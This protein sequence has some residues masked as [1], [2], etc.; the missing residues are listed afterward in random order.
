VRPEGGRDSSFL[1][2]FYNL[3]SDMLASIWLSLVLSFGLLAFE[4]H[5][6]AFPLASDSSSISPPVIVIGFVG[7]FVGHDNLVHS[8]VQL[9]ARLHHD[10]PSGVY[11]EAFENRRREI[12]HEKI[13]RL[14]DANH[15]GKLSAE[16][17]Q[18]AR[19]V[20]YGMSWGAS[21]SVTLARELEKDGI[22]VL[23]T[24]QVDSVSKVSQNDALIPG[25]VAEAANFYQTDGLL[26]G[27]SEIR[28]ADA[29]HTRIIG[30]FRFDYRANPI[31][32]PQYP[33]YDRW[34][35]KSHTEIE[36]DPAVWKHVESLIRSKLPAPGAR[37]AAEGSS[38]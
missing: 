38:Q 9:A 4:Q 1:N 33:W 16:E 14:L 29:T 11:V 26:H 2:L 8:P 5:E 22:P 35:A 25:N 28:A 24:I 34:F 27:R 12:A 20:V 23:L 36:C 15:D 18:R 17:K 19:I 13:L 3:V 30:N 7:G 31:A 6:P 10:Y 21:E 32:C 37:G